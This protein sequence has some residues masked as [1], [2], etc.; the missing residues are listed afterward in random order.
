MHTE[1]FNN[2]DL[3][4]E[5]AGSTLNVEDIEADLIQINKDIQD[6][7]QKIDN[8]KSIMVDNRYFNASNELV[9]K[10]IEV[11]LK[12]KI[13]KLNRKINNLEI[14]LNDVKNE[15]NNLNRD[16]SALK[17]QI[18]EDEKYVDI[19]NSKAGN[20]VNDS[21]KAIIKSEKEHL[22]NLKEELKQKQGSYQDILKEMELHEQALKELNE[23]KKNDELRLQDIIDSLNNPN[24][25]IDE[26]LKKND[27]EQLQNFNDSL[28]ELQKRKLEYL[29][30]PHM[31]GADAKELIIANN[32][33]MALDKIKELL[34]LVKS[35]PF[36]DLTN[37]TILDEELEKKENERTQLAN[38]ID[39][40]NY[41]AINSDFINKRIDYLDKKISTSES[42]IVQ[43]E[44]ICKNINQDIGNNLSCLIQDLE[45]QIVNIT[46][47]IAEYK[48]MLSDKNKSKKAK[49][50]LENALLKKEKE[51]DIMNNLL[52]NYKDNLLFQVNLANTM[53]KLINKYNRDID[54]KK[55]EI[56]ELKHLTII[57]ETNKDLL[58][59][60]KDK[61]KLKSINEEIKQIKNRKK[62]NK[63]PDEIYDQIEMLLANNTSVN[64][65]VLDTKKDDNFSVDDL[66]SDDFIE[67]IRYKV[68][69][70]IPAKTIQT[71]TV[72]GGTSYGA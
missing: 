4:V 64:N 35:K 14:K 47:E 25:Y 17:E 45:K 46:R 38:Y 49:A 41:A 50:N 21:Y 33:T 13:D 61:E 2:I 48:A 29:T 1:I 23:K 31:I 10:N 12:G 34:A 7:K 27:E 39:S 5:M 63:T 37:L 68:V 40:K 11:S 69:E 19:L 56:E 44:N 32:Y 51:K 43:Y 60:E 6:K 59:E 71:D 3:L 58:E 36:M 28:E 20:D 66:F 42:E 53:S 9:D 8:L 22:K 16:I 70:M 24:S 54:N 18:K 30:D 15:E 26:D 57:E 65:N 55:Q 62:Y 52:Q 67:P 72:S